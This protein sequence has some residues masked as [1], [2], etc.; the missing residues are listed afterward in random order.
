M[1]LK[2]SLRITVL[3]NLLWF[4]HKEHFWHLHFQECKWRFSEENLFTLT[5]LFLRN[6]FQNNQLL[7]DYLWQWFSK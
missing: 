7:I 4:F 6:G 5:H 3:G 1:S 2:I